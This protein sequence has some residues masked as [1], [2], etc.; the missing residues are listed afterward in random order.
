MK[1][2]IQI[3]RLRRRRNQPIQNILCCHFAQHRKLVRTCI[4]IVPREEFHS[5]H[6]NAKVQSLRFGICHHGGDVGVSFFGWLFVVGGAAYGG[7]G[8]G[9][10][11]AFA[12]VGGFG[13]G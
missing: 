2:H 6:R 1:S 10:M 7:G 11:G 13:R 12:V 4:D 5:I 3:L 8:D 9:A